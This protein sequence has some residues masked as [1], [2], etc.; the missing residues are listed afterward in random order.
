MGSVVDLFLEQVM[1]SPDACA[2]VHNDFLLTYKQLDS[3]SANIAHMVTSKG[4]QGEIVGIYSG[5]CAEFICAALGIMRAGSAYVALDSNI[6]QARLEKIID[7]AKI[8]IIFTSQDCDF[9]FSPTL[10]ICP[11][12]M[13]T[14][15][16]Y[17]TKIGNS[18]DLESVAYLIYTSGSTGEPKGTIIPHRCIVNFVCWMIDFY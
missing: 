13:S 4:C 2:I 17:S 18:L 15:S 1:N 11:V 5:R 7:D 3:I 6:P 16:E 8:K 9:N 10:D 14:F 12:D